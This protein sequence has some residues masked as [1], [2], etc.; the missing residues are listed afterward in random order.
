MRRSI[1]FFVSFVG[2][3]GLLSLN[4]IWGCGGSS[5]RGASE[6]TDT[7]AVTGTVSGVSASSASLSALGLGTKRVVSE[8]ALANEECTCYNDSGVAVGTATTDSEG[9]YTINVDESVLNPNGDASVTETLII[10]T[11]SGITHYAEVTITSD[12]TTITIDADPDT[13]LAAEALKSKLEALGFSSWLGFDFSAIV[14]DFDPFCFVRMEQEKWEL[15][16]TGESGLQGELGSMK[17]MMLASM[18]AGDFGS[19]GGF[20]DMAQAFMGGTVDASFQATAAEHASTFTGVSSASY[21]ADIADAMTSFGTMADIFAEK[22]AGGVGA[23]VTALRTKGVVDA[24]DDS[25]CGDLLLDEGAMGEAVKTMLAAGNISEFSTTFGSDAG[26]SN[27]H[28]MIKKYEVADGDFEFG[29]KW[30]PEAMM[31]IMGGFQGNYTNFNPDEMF[32]MFDSLPPDT[33]GTFDY[34]SWGAAM[35][36]D[37]Q[38]FMEGG[39]TVAAYDPATQAGFW[40]A[41]VAGGTTFDP[42]AAGYDTYKFDDTF[43]SGTLGGTNFSSCTTDPNSSACQTIV[44]GGGFTHGCFS[45]ADCATGS[46]CNVSTGLCTNS[47][48][49]E[50]NFAGTFTF[51]SPG[52]TCTAPLTGSTTLAGSGNSYTMTTLGGLPATF[53]ISGPGTCTATRNLVACGSCFFSGSGASGSMVNLSNCGTCT[54]MLMKQ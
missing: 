12:T 49:G 48:T 51:S 30:D 7:I 50:F 16:A 28:G 21:T 37:F 11:E 42:T 15:A 29:E 3:A 40:T 53:A 8:T 10:E 23:G 36:G 24:A 27:F 18:G 6:T 39:G 45:N 13:T 19:Y 2:M 35:T 38:D 34:H 14:L 43:T 20:S 4:G 31:G 32:T 22:F 44:S 33:T 25:L 41:Q 47:A 54:F 1:L 9:T 46:S 5:T 17:D 52:G 26:V